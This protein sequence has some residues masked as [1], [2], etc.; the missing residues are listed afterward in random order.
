MG[1]LCGFLRAGNHPDGMK[2]S[3]SLPVSSVLW[4]QGV[5][6][7]RGQGSG[8]R[9]EEKRRTQQRPFVSTFRFVPARRSLISFRQSSWLS[10]LRPA[11]FLLRGLPIGR[12]FAGEAGGAFFTKVPSSGPIPFLV[13]LLFVKRLQTFLGEKADFVAGFFPTARGRSGRASALPC[14]SERCPQAEVRRFS[15]AATTS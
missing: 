7:Q 3:A 11:A 8:T 15:S 12:S 13:K 5:C 6:G 2:A 14:T 9:E 4:F 1:P 10:G